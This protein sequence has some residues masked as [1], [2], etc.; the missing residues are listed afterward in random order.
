[1]SE[2]GF[3]DFWALYPRKVGKT[4]AKKAYAKALGLVPPDEIMAGVERLAGD[5]NLPAPEFIPHPATWLNRG[6]WDD[7]PYPQRLRTKADEERAIYGPG[8]AETL[9]RLEAHDAKVLA[10]REAIREHEA[11][12]ALE[13]V[14]EVLIESPEERASRMAEETAKAKAG[15]EAARAAMRARA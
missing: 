4:G 5:P 12:V 6:G 10:E 2:R 9:A 13:V 11:Q 3:D 1:M 7:A 15:V 14:R 8:H